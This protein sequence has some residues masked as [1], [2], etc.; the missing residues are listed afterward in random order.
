MGNEISE[1]SR[2]YNI[3]E[4]TIRAKKLGIYADKKPGPA[5]VLTADEERDL[6]KFGFFTVAKK[7][8]Q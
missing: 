1:V 7:V 8:F 4:S 5:P 3:P 6:V 2:K